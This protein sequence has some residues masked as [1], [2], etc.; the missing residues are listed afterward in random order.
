MS[1]LAE[2]AGLFDA[3]VRFFGGFDERDSWYGSKGSFAELFKK[4]F[5]EVATVCGW[6]KEGAG[7]HYNMATN[8]VEIRTDG[9]E[10]LATIRVHGVLDNPES[11]VV[12][13]QSLI[14]PER[15][16]L[17]RRLPIPVTFTGNIS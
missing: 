3:T 10:I 17:R 15:E 14:E 6:R 5:E 2:F 9:G 12:Y 7:A 13:V 4:E 1:M 16:A 8:C 11:A